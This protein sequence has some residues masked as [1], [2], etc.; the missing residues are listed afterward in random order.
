MRRNVELLAALAV[1]A[2]GG[3]AQATVSEITVYSAQIFHNPEYS[4]VIVFGSLVCTEGER[5]S[6]RV[7]LVG[8]GQKASGRASGV[9]EGEEVGPQTEPGAT[10][11]QARLRVVMGA[12]QGEDLVVWRVRAQTATGSRTESA[13][14]EICYQCG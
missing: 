11:W 6:V 12:F 8:E 3:P 14:V 5:F 9:C 10:F 7:S 4:R 13:F 2:G 1:V